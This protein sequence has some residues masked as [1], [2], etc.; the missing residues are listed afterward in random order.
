M[1]S[2]SQGS[3]SLEQDSKL[4]LS[5]YKVRIITTQPR[6]SVKLFGILKRIAKIILNCNLR[7]WVMRMLTKLNCLGIVPNVMSSNPYQFAIVLP[8][9]VI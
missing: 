4:G 7:R 9:Q 8:L 6:W 5:E 1:I 2:S 3:W